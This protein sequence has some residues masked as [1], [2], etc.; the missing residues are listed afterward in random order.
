M[1]GTRQFRTG[2]GLVLT[3]ALGAGSLALAPVLAPVLAQDIPPRLSLDLSASLRQASNPDLAVTG[4]ASKTSPA[5]RFGLSY[6]DTTPDQAFRISL[7]GAFDEAGLSDPALRLSY[8]RKGANATLGLDLA[9]TDT[10]VDLFEPQALPDGTLS[11]SDLTAATGRVQTTNGS[12]TLKTGTEGPLGFDLTA[13][14]FDRDYGQTNDPSVYDSRTASLGL[15]AHLRG[16]AGGDLGLSLAARNADYDDLGQTSKETR[17]LTLTW[18]RELGGATR[19]ATSLGVT[20][21]ETRAF[22]QDFAGSTGAVG[23]LALARDMANGTAELGVSITRDAK[24]ARTS[25]RFARSLK[26]A[27]GEFGAELGY[28]ARA[29]ESGLATGKLSWSQELAQDKI[30]LALSRQVVTSETEAD[31]IQDSLKASWSHALS[32]TRSLGLTYSLNAITETGGA[33]VD[34]VT[35]HSLKAS[36]M[37]D[38]GRDWALTTGVELRQSDR[39]SM[40]TAEDQAIFLT[41]ARRFVLLP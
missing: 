40:G 21:A 19:L 4:G 20:Q 12:L 32:E 29:G 13:Q 23:G 11:Y 17:S 8:D 30:S 10:P 1:T 26:L 41:L 5:L 22:G 18:G 15:T 9:F 27:T 35:R 7:N 37:Q 25:L 14:V 34:D 2:C 16:V 36:L 24:G 33:Q 3:G 6:A 28:G 31:T 39:E 38:L